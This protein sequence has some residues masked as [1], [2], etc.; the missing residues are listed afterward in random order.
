MKSSKEPPMRRRTDVLALAVSCTFA[1]SAVILGAGVHVARSTVPAVAAPTSR[2]VPVVVQAAAS[3]AQ[4]RLRSDGAGLVG[5]ASGYAARFSADGFEYVPLTGGRPDR[6][7]SWTYRLTSVTVGGRQVD[8][9]LGNRLPAGAGTNVAEFARGPMLERYVLRDD[10]VEQ[11][12]VLPQALGAGDVVVAGRIGGGWHAAD[13]RR[14]SAGLSFERAGM[15]ALQYGTVTVTDASHHA[16]TAP[17]FMDGTDLRITV[18]GNWLRHARYP[19][20]IDPIISQALVMQGNEDHNATSPAIA[21]DVKRNRY[22][23]VFD[24]AEGLTNT[25]R[26]LIGVLISAAGAQIPP[27]IPIA[28]TG[29]CPPTCDSTDKFDPDVAYNPVVDQYLV[30]WSHDFGTDL[31]T[32]GERLNAATLAVTGTVE[33]FETGIGLTSR[34]PVVGANTTLGA[35]NPWLV[36]WD[37]TVDDDVDTDVTMWGRLV[38]VTGAPGAAFRVS[39]VTTRLIDRN[40]AVAFNPRSG[41]YLVVFES[42]AV[43]AGDFDIRG[44]LVNGSTGATTALASD[45]SA[46]FGATDDAHAPQLSYSDARDVFAVTWRRETAMTARV[47]GISGAGALFGEVS[48]GSA[49]TNDP[50]VVAAL[51][52]AFGAVVSSKSTVAPVGDNDYD[53]IDVWTTFD[54]GA[55]LGYPSPDTG[56]APTNDDR[57]ARLAPINPFYGWAFQ[58]WEHW[59]VVGVNNEFDVLGSRLSMPAYPLISAGAN[60]DGVGGADRVVVRMSPVSNQMTWFVKPSSGAANLVVNWGTTGDVPVAG[61]YA[62][63]ART[64][65]AVW[66]P[67]NGVWYVAPSDGSATYGLAWGNSALGDRP[68]PADYDGDGKTDL[69]IFRP[70]ASAGWYILKSSTGTPLSAA[71]GTWGDVPVPGDFDGDGKADLAVWRP[72]NGGWY[73][74]RSTG[75]TTAVNWGIPSDHPVLGDFDGDGKA[76]FAIFRTSNQGWYVKTSTGGTLAVNFGLASGG[77]LP[78]PADFDGDGKA[79]VAVWR[80]SNGTFF[81]QYSGGGTLTQPWGQA[82]DLPVAH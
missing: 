21:Y 4:R 50:A 11:V 7:R 28:S 18:D 62:G 6:D 72:S 32:E 39:T 58:T 69:A 76:D 5:G 8:A 20:A 37:D 70:G 56:T 79:D 71:W 14:E 29:P 40:G 65:Y 53:L 51:D 24:R 66:R 81:A 16:V 78:I 1:S 25:P 10:G 59:S 77:D 64:D 67:G 22:F 15:A 54:G 46:A 57:H 48:F 12:F 55:L 33:G 41:N 52:G 38:P 42:Q 45:I 17:V 43:A 63:D 27:E 3:R 61:N 23:I 47:R 44:V 68:V 82:F 36:A 35:T 13:G 31:D 80:P 30:V 73:V 2:T 60:F 9:A 49:D 19:V 74:Q 75:G 34:H 26:D